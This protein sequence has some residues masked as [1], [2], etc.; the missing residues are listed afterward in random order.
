MVAMNFY[1]EHVKTAIEAGI[2][3]IISGAGLL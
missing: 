1:E 3:I 2:D